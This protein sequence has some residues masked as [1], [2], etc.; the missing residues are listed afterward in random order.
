MNLPEPKGRREFIKQALKWLSAAGMGWA[1]LGKT[2]L[3]AL[4]REAERVILPPGTLATELSDREPSLIDPQNLE[5][6]DLADFGTMGRTDLQVDLDTWRLQ[7]TG[8]VDQPLSLTYERLNSRMTFKRK[9]LLICPGFFSFYAEWTCLSLNDLLKEAGLKPG[10]VKVN[11]SG[12][13]DPGGTAAKFALEEIAQGKVYLALGVN[14]VPL[15]VKHGY[16]VRAV[17]EDHYGGQWV[18]YVHT[19]EVI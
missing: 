14:G 9:T 4:A 16:P 5:I 15:P 18:K 3:E 13:S 2:G 19:V 12:G 17:A 11:I 10:A 1:L 8:Q 7:V 6:T